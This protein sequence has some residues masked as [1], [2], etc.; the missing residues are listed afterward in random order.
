MRTVIAAL[1]VL[2]VDASAAVVQVSSNGMLI[3][4]EVTIAA[5]PSKTFG[6]MV[7]QVGAWWSSQH[8]YSKDAKNL[9]IEAKAGGCFCEA[10]RQG[11]IEHL[12][13]VYV[14]PGETIRFTGGMGPLQSQGVAGS[15]TW[16]FSPSGDGTTLT[17]TYS[18]GGFMEGG[19]EKMAPAVDA[20][21]A[22]QV[23]RLK[24]YVET[25]APQ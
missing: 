14:A 16:K 20:M 8:T 23:Q 13:V 19:F 17:L 25:G 3:R 18:I 11:S 2:C 10:L 9:S 12:R 22:E 1:C 5:P 6:A 15:Q 21:L 7:F 24:R 4:H